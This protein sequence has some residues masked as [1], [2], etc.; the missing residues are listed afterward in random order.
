MQLISPVTG[1]ELDLALVA[2]VK[3]HVTSPLKWEVLRVVAE[4][5]GQWIQT[6]DL[7]SLLHRTSTELIPVL[8]EMQ[9]EG[10]LNLKADG[11]SLELPTLEPTTVVLKRLRQIAMRSPEMRGLIAANLHL[12]HGQH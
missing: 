5:D 2:F 3:C 7:A 12:H 8:R 9:L 10:L 11:L 6:M 4:R 1:A